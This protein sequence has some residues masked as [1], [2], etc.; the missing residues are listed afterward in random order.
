MKTLTKF[1]VLTVLLALV[2]S[3]TLFAKQPSPSKC[4]NLLKKGNERFIAGVSKHPHTN[5][6]RLAQAGKENQGNHA[7]AT[8]ITCS[9]SRVP[10]ERLFDAGIMDIFVIRV[11]GNVCDIDEV[12]SI[13]Y[14]VA[15][16]NTP[17]LV[18]LGHTQC[19]AVTAVTHA[20]NGTGHPLELNI[21]PLVDNI[22]PAVRKA[23]KNH[24]G[25]HGD[26]IIPYAIE[27]NVWQGTEDLFM[28]SPATRNLVNSGKLKIVGAIYDVGTGTVRWLPEH[29]VTQILA[30][31][32]SNPSRAMNAMAGS[33]HGGSRASVGGSHGSEPTHVSEASHGATASSQSSTHGVTLGQVKSVKLM[34]SSR[35]A[36]LDKE[37]HHV[38]TASTFSLSKD[39]EG[40]ST[41]WMILIGLAIFL[42]VGGLL[43][44]S[45]YYSNLG[46]AG[47]LYGGFGSLIVL[48]L[49]VSI[50]GYYFIDTVNTKAEIAEAIL[51]VD[52]MLG[53]AGMLQNEFI[54]IGIEDAERG[55]EILDQHK[56]LMAEFAEKVDHIHEMELAA[57]EAQALKQ[58]DAVMAEYKV[59]F[60]ELVEKYHE[61]E[62]FNEEL[63]EQGELVDKQLAEIL[64]EHEGDLH[65]LEASGASMAKITAQTDLLERLFESEL[66][67]AKVAH[68]EAQFLLDKRITHV[69]ELEQLLGELYANLAVVREMVPMVAKDKNEEVHDLK[70]LGLIDHEL[71]EYQS[72][73]SL[74]IEDELIVEADMLK[75]MEELTQ[76]NVIG[77]AMVKHITASA[78]ELKDDAETSSILLAIIVTL[79]G[80]LLAFALSRNITKPV[81]RIVESLSQSVEQIG[82][83]SE[84]VSGASQ[85][86]AQ[87][88]SE[89]ASSLE[90]TSAALEEMAGMTRQNSDN[91]KQANTLSADASAGAEKGMEAMKKMSEAMIGIKKSSDETAK[92]IKVIDEIA[93][94]TN[95]LA[96]NAAVEAARAGEAGKGFAVVA[97]E[98]RNLA[99]RSSE[100]AKETSDLIEGSQ[101]SADDGVRSSE[102]L[103][104]IFKEVSESINKVTNLVSEVAAASEE[105]SKGVD[106]LNTTA[107]QMDQITQ[108]NASNAEETSGASEELAALAQ[109]LQQAVRELVQVVGGSK[110]QELQSGFG[111]DTRR[112]S[113]YQ[114]KAVTGVTPGLKD[115][116]HKLVAKK[117]VKANKATITTAATATEPNG[118]QA[119]AE[120]QADGNRLEKGFPL[121]EEENEPALKEF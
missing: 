75:C 34:N 27:Q 18:V 29:K 50:S 49:V 1:V 68:V 44:R 70:T 105:Q 56:E 82:S 73:L 76:A 23:M 77:Q 121:N 78:T 11:A 16:V 13:E 95:L 43:W 96:L 14:G 48:A 58:F 64:H 53:Q 85:T 20:I 10:V 42:I 116:I 98:V 36:E 104:T 109:Q 45:D 74:V 46:V 94:Q 55:E 40:M 80:T 100:A 59:T 97:E 19:G 47:K 4:L 62:R 81:N 72:V 89:Q 32:E 83:A 65:A 91:A 60:A 39:H 37:R 120:L 108:Q 31:V 24:P 67:M 86:L 106:E 22:E 21:P 84:Q 3:M 54:I 79:L 6:L 15:H 57:S 66:L 28:R 101:K 71:A 8:V 51:E 25:V 38:A 92:I 69:K 110:S 118:G 35:L 52:G 12:G 17:V 5:A 9:D 90:E 7:Y 112:P 63:N 61:I 102:E 107:G 111:Y 33:S 93:F 87:G 113:K 2:S 119:G 117:A 99:M 26:D 115:R 88:A 41:F 103:L 114:D 30:K